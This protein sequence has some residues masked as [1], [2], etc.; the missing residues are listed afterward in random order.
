ME[1]N[2]TIQLGT[3]V[4]IEEVGEWRERDAGGGGGDTEREMYLNIQRGEY[5]HVAKGLLSSSSG[6]CCETLITSRLTVIEGRD[7]TS[8][9]CDGITSLSLPGFVKSSPRSLG[10]LLA[11]CKLT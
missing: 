3:D 10:L 1:L 6:P 4:D 7:S 2:C 5:L 11:S 9:C 8:I